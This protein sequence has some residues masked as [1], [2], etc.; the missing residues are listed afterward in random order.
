MYFINNVGERVEP[1]DAQLAAVNA[2]PEKTNATKAFVAALGDGQE[3]HVRLLDDLIMVATPP[4][5]NP[6]LTLLGGAQ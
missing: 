4:T 1:T 3:R 2:I 5:Y 6:A